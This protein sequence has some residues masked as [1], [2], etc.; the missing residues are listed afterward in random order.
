MHHT[1]LNVALLSLLALVKFLIRLP[2]SRL[3]K[4]SPWT[5][6]AR[7]VSL[8]CFMVVRNR[9]E[10]VL[11]DDSVEIGHRN[12]LMRFLSS[13]KTALG[14][15]WSL[16]RFIAVSCTVLLGESLKKLMYLFKGKYIFEVTSR[17]CCSTHSTPTSCSTVLSII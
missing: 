7:C 13:L 16:D 4:M 8:F 1:T 6:R 5:L 12:K 14:C 2:M 11:S 9:V 3:S 17:G 15:G 10:N